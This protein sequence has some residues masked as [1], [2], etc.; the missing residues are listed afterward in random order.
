MYKFKFTTLTPLHISNGENLDQNFHYTV[1]RDEFYRIDQN[2]FA[3]LLAKKEKIDFTKEVNLATI[4]NWVKKYQLDIVDNASSYSVAF[5]DNFKFHLSN[6]RAQ[7]RRQVIEFINSNGKFYIPASSIKGALLTVLGLETS[8]IQAGQNANVKDKVVFHDSEFIDYKKFKIYRTENR[9]PA[10]N[11]IC[12]I[13]G[14]KFEMIMQKNGNIS[15]ADLK[16]KLSNYSS[17]QIEL[18]L[19]NIVKFKSRK[20]QLKGADHFEKALEEIDR[21]KFRNDE[22]LI[23]IG[24]GGGSWFKVFENTIPK[25]KSKSPSPRRKGK[26]EEAHTTF[27]VLIKNTLHHLGWCKLE[28]EKI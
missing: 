2:K 1:F 26:M 13:P 10:N 9:P 18:A 8:G 4:E 20:D 16:S 27:S 19:E 24:Y 17:T 21:M 14:T 22:Y 15:I 28:I 5:D 7:G 12:L 11:L 6:P 23:N 25:F 3:I